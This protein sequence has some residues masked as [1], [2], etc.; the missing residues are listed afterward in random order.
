MKPPNVLITAAAGTTGFPTTVEA[1]RAGLRVRALV[2]RDGPRADELRAMGAEV[3]AGSLD[4]PADVAAALAG[5]ERAYYTSPWTPGHLT[6]SVL[7]AHAAERA[8]LG[9]LVMMSQWLADPTHPSVHT[10]EAWHSEEVFR[11]SPSFG[12][13]VINPGWFADNYFAALDSIAQFGLM[14]MPLGDGRNAPPSNEDIA[15]VVVALLEDPDPHIGRAYRP[16][17]PRLLSPP[18]IAETFSAVLGRKVR[19]RDAPMK[20]FTKVARGL[21]FTDFQIAQIVTY[22]ED[23]KRDAFAVGGPTTV[24]ADLTGRPAEEF[25]DI[26][27]R[28]IAASPTAVRSVGGTLR[29]AANLTRAMLTRAPDLSTL[30]TVSQYQ[31]PTALAADSPTWRQRHVVV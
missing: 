19:Y 18:E 28:N 2:H 31:L 24:M 17:G 26:V 5:I 10:R 21:G 15:R 30:G 9:A 6:R 23:Y 3:V 12:T 7:F 22:L 16:T 13:V 27:R 4:D 11:A 29:A 14:A 25:E 20:L 8:G 1:L